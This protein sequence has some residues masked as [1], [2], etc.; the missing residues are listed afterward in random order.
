[1]G[2]PTFCFNIVLWNFKDAMPVSFESKLFI[3]AAKP[4]PVNMKNCQ[5]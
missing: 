4:T 5:I 3:L 2:T 1:M